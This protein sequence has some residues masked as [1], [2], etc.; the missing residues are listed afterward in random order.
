MTTR[1]RL[2]IGILAALLLLAGCGG[3]PPTIPPA[4]TLTPLSATEAPVTA[5]PAPTPVP[6]PAAPAAAPSPTA[7][8]EDSAREVAERMVAAK[9]QAMRDRDIGKYMALI[10]EAD[11]EHY[12]EQRNWFLIY[13]DAITSEFAIQVI[14]ARKI[15]DATVVATLR[16]RYLYG[17]DRS[18]RTV[19]CEERFIKTGGGWRD[20]DLY[21]ATRETPHFV[22]RCQDGVGDKAAEFAEEAEGAYASVAASLRLEPAGRTT[23]KLYADQEML[24]QSSDIRVAYLFNGWAEDGES[25]KMYARRERSTTAPVIAHELAHKVTLA[26]SDSQCSWLAEG[27]ATYYGNQPFRGG[28]PVKVGTLTAT[29]VSRPIAWLEETNLTGLTDS[30]AIQVYYAA[31]SMLVE[32]I[33]GTY[34][35]ERPKDI[36]RELARYPRNDRGFDYSAMELES[37]DRLHRAIATVLGVDMDTFNRKWLAWAAAQGR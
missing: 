28:N 2:V 30:K 23:M 25:I 31:A 18:V 3:P 33:V 7:P 10:N 4:A 35:Q 15:D 21:F 19:T 24:R 11:S 13:L 8:V 37:Q 20:A 1:C 12:T 22:V 6:L 16:Q 26:I 34:G 5:T 32:F 29:D 17:T 14:D 27:L 36:L 9:L